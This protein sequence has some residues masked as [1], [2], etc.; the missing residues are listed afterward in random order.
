M[1]RRGVLWR[2][3]GIQFVSY[4]HSEADID[5]TIRMAGEAFEHLKEVLDSGRLVSSAT[6]S[7]S[8]VPFQR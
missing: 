3:G 2:P 1:A 5:Y 6:V 4:S 7:P 8:S